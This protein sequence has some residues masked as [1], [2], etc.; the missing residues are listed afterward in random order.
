MM[1][2]DVEVARFALKAGFQSHGKLESHLDQLPGECGDGVA[3]PNGDGHRGDDG[4][5]SG[6]EE[7]KPAEDD[8]CRVD[9]MCEVAPVQRKVG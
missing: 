3:D 4:D 5:D 7:L 6:D 9:S 1:S 2:S 8:L